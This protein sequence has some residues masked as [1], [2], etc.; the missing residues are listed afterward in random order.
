MELSH[1]WKSFFPVGGSTVSPLLLSHPHSLPLGPLFF[2]PNPNPS[3]NPNPLSLLFSSPSLAPALHLPPHLLP[4]RF[5]LSSHPS[6]IL[7]STASSLF[8][9]PPQ[10]DTASSFLHNRIHLLYHPH[11]PNA[12]VFFPTGA[13]DHKIGFFLLTFNHGQLHTRLDPNGDVFLASTGSAHRILRISVTPVADSCLLHDPCNVIGYLLATTLYSVHWFSVKHDSI[14]D[15]PSVVYLG[16]KTF[17]ICPVAHA[18][19]SPHILEESLVLLETGQLFL[20]DLNSHG[21][22]DAAFK[23]T[24]LK[25][26]WNDS[27]NKVWLSCEFSWHPRIFVVARSDAVFLVDLRLKECS[28]SCL[29]KIQTL[30]MYAP[31]E[32]ERFLALSRAAPDNF[33][34][35]L[36]STTLL[37]LC[38]VRKPLLPV[39]QWIHGVQEP[40]FMSVVRLSELRSHSRGDHF[41]LAS[42]TGF[43]IMLGSFWNCE[44]NIFCYGSILPFRKG[45]ITSKINPNLCAWEL[46]V[47]INLSGR[48]CHCGG[49]LLR[50]E[51]SKDAIP[52]W[53]DWQLKKEIVLGFGILR[54]DL[55]ALLCEPDENGGFTLIRL[56]SSGRLELQRYHASALQAT[57]MEDCHDQAF[58]LDRH[59]LY[60]ESDEKYKFPKAFHY[61]KLDYLYAYATG[62]LAQFLVKKLEKNSIDYQDKE[63]LCAEVHELLCEKLNACGF[64]QSRSCPAITSVF[65]DIKLP[66]SLHEVALRRL[67]ADLPIE[68]LQ[69]AFF[70]YA[71]CHEVIG[72]LDQNRVA[73][74]FLAVPDLPQLPPFFLR[75]SSPHGN[76]D[77]VGPVIPFPVLLVLNEF[78]DGCSNLEGG[79]FSVEAELGLKYK[80]VMQVAGE[81]AVSVYG[82]TH[83]DDHAVSLADDGEETWVGSSKPKSFLL[84]HPGAFNSSATGHVQEKSVYSDTVYDTFISHVPE[85]KSNEQTES[86]G[87]EIFDDLSPVELRFDAPVKKLEPQGLKAYNLLKRQMSKWQESFDS[88]QEF[89]IQSRFEKTS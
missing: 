71:E 89:C 57:S 13:N 35:A 1:E 76:H 68:L 39:L 53:I 73:L 26:P 15:R 82:P 44:F 9:P 78:W 25:V 7:P 23:G 17:K 12:L 8:T 75:K 3:P 31:D 29:M 42:Q 74:E 28:V 86:V 87:Q 69:L 20:F 45:A 22:S 72:D 49:C 59:L 80:E 77:I 46:P 54:N 70:S 14:L 19:W 38:D 64:G 51:F 66:A 56:M 63:P 11:L 37:L 30:R 81:I 50:K 36:A 47:E 48:E 32:N 65:N 61:L 33:Y 67:W 5:L 43:C 83:L 55:A 2:N 16:A 79:E 40:C 10:N 24:R 34:F 21:C 4:S 27:K 52:E 62:D 84:Y 85:K 18:C 88:Y 60:L 6:S 58:C 41:K